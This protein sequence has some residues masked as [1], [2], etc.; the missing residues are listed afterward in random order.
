MTGVQTCALPIYQYRDSI[1]TGGGCGFLIS[2]VAT[3]TV[4]PAPVVTISAAPVTK[5]F[6]GLTTTLRATVAPNAAATYQ[7][8]RDGVA[9]TGATTST[10]LVNI[11]RLGRYTVAVTDV[12]SCASAA[13]A[14]TPASIAI[15]DSVNTA[16]LFIYPSPNTGQFQVRHYTNLGDGSPVPAA[17]NVYDE[18]GSLVFN[19]AYRI[20]G[21]Y[22]P[23][24]V[25]ISPS[26]G[27]GIYRVDLV[28]TRGG[29]IKTGTVIIF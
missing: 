25:T 21:G 5:L 11:D 9:V 10:Y 24:N 6:P 7:W 23:M 8:F 4:N 13:G 19:Q 28:D 1:S 29:R 2:P 26:H 12:N 16:R 17:V 20:G 18:K 15:T 27:R 14:S 3:L 22:Q